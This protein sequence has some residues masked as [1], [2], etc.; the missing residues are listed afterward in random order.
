MRS[1]HMYYGI[2]QNFM[3]TMLSLVPSVNGVLEKSFSW[4]KIII[5]GM[6]NECTPRFCL[7]DRPV[8]AGGVRKESSEVRAPCITFPDHVFKTAS[9]NYCNTCSL[10]R[11][12]T[13][14]VLSACWT[15]NPS[16]LSTH[17]GASLLTE[18]K[19]FYVAGFTMERMLSGKK[20]SN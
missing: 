9:I 14:Q 17:R 10:H 12:C 3:G 11:T 19:T 16:M 8:W 4:D 6:W 15:S 5:T 2:L 18:K 13:R 1:K 20:K 7:P